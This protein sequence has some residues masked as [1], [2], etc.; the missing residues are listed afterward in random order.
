MLLSLA[1]LRG[2]SSSAWLTA[3]GSG[4]TQACTAGV[5][6]LVL[7]SFSI[8]STC[9]YSQQGAC[10]AS[11]LNIKRH[12]S[13]PHGKGGGGDTAVQGTQRSAAQRS[14]AA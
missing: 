3:Q 6:G 7:M 12:S 1:C 11:A 10:L 13:R 2:S 8:N 4:G 9:T 5:K 14:K